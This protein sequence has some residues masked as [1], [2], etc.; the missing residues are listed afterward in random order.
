MTFQTSFSG[1]VCIMGA[2]WTTRHTFMIQINMTT[3]G[4]V[5]RTL[6][7]KKQSKKKV[8]SVY[9]RQKQ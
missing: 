4:T 8:A 3:F 5:P 1:F 6:K 2:I 7:Y 9:R